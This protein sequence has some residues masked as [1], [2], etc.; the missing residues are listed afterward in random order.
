MFKRGFAQSVV[1]CCAEPC[2]Q[3]GVGIDAPI[4]RTAYVAVQKISLS[5]EK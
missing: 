5:G 4:P 1:F 2:A 3:Y